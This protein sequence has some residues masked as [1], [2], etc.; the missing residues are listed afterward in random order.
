M[1]LEECNSEKL[2]LIGTPLE[3][4]PLNCD[5]LPFIVQKI[6]DYIVDYGMFIE[7]K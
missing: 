7:I 3:N 2:I 4:L 6:Y 5:G 1:L